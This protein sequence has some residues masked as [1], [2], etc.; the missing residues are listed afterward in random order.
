[1]QLKKEQGLPVCH[2]ALIGSLDGPPI[3]RHM[4]EALPRAIL[5]PEIVRATFIGLPAI[6]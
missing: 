5:P 3:R 1:V 6:A 2:D 4:I